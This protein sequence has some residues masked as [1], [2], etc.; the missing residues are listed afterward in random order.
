MIERKSVQLR[1]PATLT[2]RKGAQLKTN[3]KNLKLK[4]G[5]PEGPADGS[6]PDLEQRVSEL[7][8]A[9]WGDWEDYGDEWYDDYG[10]EDYGW[11]EEWS[12]TMGDTQPWYDSCFD[13]DGD[14]AGDIDGYTCDTY[15]E[16]WCGMYDTDGFV[17]ADMCC[18]CGGGEWIDMEGAIDEALEEAG[19][20]AEDMDSGEAEAVVEDAIEEVVEEAEEAGADTADLDAEAADDLADAATEELADSGVDEATAEVAAEEVA[21]DTVEEVVEDAAAEEESTE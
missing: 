3:R 14:A 9:I 17:S 16:G 10:F 5:G 15:V 7:E 11:E 19:V 2:K 20:E 12:P 13:T 1:K 4:Q 21:D 18:A 8:D 6:G